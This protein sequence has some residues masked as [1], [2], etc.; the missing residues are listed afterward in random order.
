[1]PRAVHDGVEI[2]FAERGAGRPIVLL[3]GL[4]LPG[5]VWRHRAEELAERDFRVVVPDNRGTGGSDAPL[6]PYSMAEIAGDVVAVM[7]EAGLDSAIV[8]G[9]S[10]GGMV[11]Q[12]LVLDHPR[13]VDGLMLVSTTCGF[14]PGRLPRPTAIWL[15][16]KMVFAPE[17]VTVGET[18]RLLAHAD[19]TERLHAF[20]ERVDD[21]MADSP[22]PTSA[23]L[24]QLAAVLAHHTGRR[25]REIRVPTRVITGDADVLV[26]PENSEILAARI[27]AARLRVIPR[28]GHIAIHEHPEALLEEVA[29]LREEV[30]GAGA[31]GRVR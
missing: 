9:V 29:A 22:T 28:G 27:P 15:L 10:F 14:P 21:V 26:P 1:M 30:D 8:C 7:D 6:P 13:R 11:A 5:S 23:T 12:H 25:L 3:M 31:R 16:L 4:S 19:S 2:A 20:L 17:S 18:R 24:G